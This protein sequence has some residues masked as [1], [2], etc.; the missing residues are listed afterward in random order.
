M[1]NIS[2]AGREGSEKALL[3]GL[4]RRVDRDGVCPPCAPPLDASDRAPFPNPRISTLRRFGVPSRRS[5][6]RA[7][8]VQIEIVLDGNCHPFTHEPP[9]LLGRGEE[10]PFSCGPHAGCPHG[11]G[12]G[13]TDRWMA[14]LRRRCDASS[15]AHFDAHG[16]WSDTSAVR[17]PSHTVAPRLRR[18]RLLDPG[19]VARL[20]TLHVELGTSH[21]GLAARLCRDTHC[22]GYRVSLRARAKSGYGLPRPLQMRLGSAALGSAA[23]IGD[24]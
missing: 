21:A 18:K 9:R 14:P 8:R 16:R 5:H 3:T 20:R 15:H 2:G 22:F 10:S 17:R 24:I 19:E 11:S 7:Q 1:T 6:K 23:R 13:L 12:V 4:A